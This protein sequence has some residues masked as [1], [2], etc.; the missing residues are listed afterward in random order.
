[1]FPGVVALYSKA[2]TPFVIHTK[3]CCNFPFFCVSSIQDNLD[4][5]RVNAENTRMK[6]YIFFP[7]LS[8]EIRVYHVCCCTQLSM[9]TP[10]PRPRPF[11]GGFASHLINCC[12]QSAMQEFAHVER[13]SNTISSSSSSGRWTPAI[14][15]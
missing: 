12:R 4:R 14:N 15:M 11:H 9:P 5:Y 7:K 3:L 2:T 8:F 1:M 10:R 6:G 13:L